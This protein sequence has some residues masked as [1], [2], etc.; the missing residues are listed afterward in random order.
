M[1][2]APPR[3]IAW[4]DYVQK[5]KPLLPQAAFQRRPW[6]L[7][8]APVNY[9]LMGAGV[10]L[11]HANDWPGSSVLG[12]LLIAQA[13]VSS[14]FF[15]HEVLHG[16]VIKHRGLSELVATICFWPVWVSPA[17]WKIWHN[18]DHHGNAQIPDID[19]DVTTR[20][21]DLETS[22]V[23]RRF[24]SWPSPVRSAVIFGIFFVYLTVHG[25][26]E[27]GRRLRRIPT[28][29]GRLIALAQWIL[30]PLIACSALLYWL[31]PADFATAYLAPFFLANLG[32]MLYIATNH[33]LSPLNDVNDPLLNSLTVRH[34]RWLEYLHHNF[35]YHVEHHVFPAMTPMLAPV[36]R[37]LLREHY[38]DRYQEMTHFRAI[39]LLASM[40]KLYET[41]T[42]QFD[43]PTGRRTPT[44]GT[45]LTD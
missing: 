16:A 38:G 26:V 18:Q 36:L 43:P 23:R 21:A 13:F 5:L 34:W 39:G 2:V 14:A 31:G 45:A 33:M 9:A 8:W 44:L 3:E 7:F 29:A 42:L 20:L 28:F 12:V 24:F 6:R 19:P 15:G 10:W 30:L 41:H 1:I 27:Q 4:Q 25:A 11:I 22:A 37:N 35:G 17:L 40:P 32:T